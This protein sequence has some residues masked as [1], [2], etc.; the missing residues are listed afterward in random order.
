MMMINTTSGEQD[1]SAGDVEA[2]PAE[3]PKSMYK[4]EI[5][6]A[7][8]KESWLGKTEISSHIFHIDETYLTAA[9]EFTDIEL[10]SLLQKTVRNRTSRRALSMV[11]PKELFIIFA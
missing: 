7:T 2:C 6:D 3:L 1:L 5:L 10:D 11:R 9:A 8:I 4:P